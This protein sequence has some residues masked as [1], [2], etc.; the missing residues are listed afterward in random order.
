[1]ADGG[2]HANHRKRLRERYMTHGLDNFHDH[3]VIELLLTFAIPRKDV[4]PIAH[5][6]I[7]RFGSLDAVFEATV[8]EL[9][10][11]PG[12]GE[13][14]AAMINLIPQVSKR[15]MAAKNRLVKVI[16]NSTDAGNYILPSYLCEKDEV[17][18]LLC[19]DSMRRITAFK[20]ISRGVV[21]IVEIS[22][23][24]VIEVAL[25]C[26]AVSVIISHNHPGGI[27]YP[28]LED[29]RTTEQLA[30]ALEVVGIELSDHIIVAGDDYVSLADSGML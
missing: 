22:V 3:N 29:R 16:A 13:N 21:N 24:R 5:D 23:R 11:V 17:V 1:M 25:G 14:A 6:L 7:A 2:I 30:Q 15:Y 8:E 26:N 18:M 28:S 4:N 20:E 12:I 27:A 9:V 19:M 10:A